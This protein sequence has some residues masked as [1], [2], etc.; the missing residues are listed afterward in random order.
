M[1]KRILTPKDMLTKLGVF[2]PITDAVP[3][4]WILVNVANREQPC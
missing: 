2:L 1:C 3:A 4:F